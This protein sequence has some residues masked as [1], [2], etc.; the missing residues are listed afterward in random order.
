MKSFF[1][2]LVESPSKCS[3]I[4]KILNLHYK[5]KRYIVKATVGHIRDLKK[6]QLGINIKNNFEGNFEL[7]Y[8]KNNLINTLKKLIN[9][10]Q[11]VYLAMDND[12]EGMRIAYDVKDFFKIKNYKRI[13]F[14]E[15]TKD[16]IIKAIENPVK[17][18]MNI[19]NAQMCRRFLD[20]IIGFMISPIVRKNI[21][22]SS[23]GRCQS[24]ITKMIIQRENEINNLEKKN[25]Y[26]LNGK[27]NLNLNGKLNKTFNTI[28]ECKSFLEKI[29][30]Y[31]FF[32][33]EIKEEIK[34]KNPPPPFITST[35]QQ[36][37]INKFKYSVKNISNILQ[38]LYQRGLITYIRTDSTKISNMF[39]NKL[40]N[41]IINKYGEQEY[42]FRKYNSK[43]KGAQLAHEC[44]RV[45]N[46]NFDANKLNSLFEKNIYNEILKR[47]L[48]TQ[49]KSKKYKEI[50]VII[51]TKEENDLEFK[52]VNEETIEKGWTILYEKNKIKKNKNIEYKKN[53]N[54][55]YK[56]IESK[57]KN[58]NSLKLYN[59]AMLIKELEKKGIGRPSTYSNLIDTI[60]KRGYVKKDTKKGIEKEVQNIKLET[61]SML[62][63]DA[64]AS[65]RP[66]ADDV[67]SLENNKKITIYNEKEITGN[68][69]KR[70]VSTTLGKKVVNFLSAQIDFLM[71]Y[72]Y[73]SNMEKE[74]DEIS[75]G[76]LNWKDTLKN[77]Y[78][79]LNSKIN[80]INNIN[81][82][83]NNKMLKKI[84][85]YK[86]ISY[87]L[88]KNHFGYV[89]QSD[90]DRIYI[91]DEI[92]ENDIKTF[93]KYFPRYFNY[94]KKEG[95][96][97][98]GKYG[99]YMIYNNSNY[100][101]K[102]YCEEHNLEPYKLKTDD[103]IKII[104][105][106]S[107][108]K[109]KLGN[110]GGYPLY[111]CDGK[112]GMYFKYKNKNKSMKKVIKELNR[113]INDFTYEDL[114]EIVSN[115]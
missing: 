92:N 77:H 70:F 82:K 30:Y 49:I 12:R 14:T 103:C 64:S 78:N 53:T 110:I 50:I 93:K 20:R 28:N 112:Y 95:K 106:Q 96:I 29:K 36:Q 13:I 27:F 100:N 114:V 76:N 81:N 22:A 113:E 11:L 97:I 67:P 8:K 34:L 57:Y 35:V 56:S 115:F 71:D 47:T 111:L 105:S 2:V 58:N 45:T 63:N 25:Y 31:N 88:R 65:D 75:L 16:A 55:F 39:L 89:L 10:S 86:G 80:N 87:E 9:E 6:K 54:I 83:R 94:E 7:I 99:Y 60:Q 68:Y 5:N 66:M 4:Q 42:Q 69:N 37:C 98:Y 23:A 32:I 79:K 44:I 18:D 91:T 85:K 15:I 24:V 104:Q 40:K 26:E 43:V 61:F 107:Q 3:K 74:L 51:S 84:L 109:K 38:K 1:L 48:A 19:V 59:E 101:I 17:I 72:N 108:K 73:T 33:K 90:N 52:C 46:I 41:H 21:L 102:K 62:S